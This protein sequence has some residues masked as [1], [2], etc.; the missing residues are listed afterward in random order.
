VTRKFQRHL[1]RAPSRASFAIWKAR[2][3]IEEHSCEE[4]SLKQNGK[5]VN[6]HANYLSE[7]FKQVTGINFVE[8]WRD[9]AKL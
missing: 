7:K 2:R 9:P 1:R 4:L 6:M 5:A 3:F 8:F